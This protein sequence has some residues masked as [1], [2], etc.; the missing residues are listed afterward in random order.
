[1]KQKKELFNKVLNL[2]TFFVLFLI[3]FLIFEVSGNNE[4]KKSILG[5]TTQRIQKSIKIL[6]SLSINKLKSQNNQIHIMFFGDLIYDRSVYLK[7]TG[8][9]QLSGHF[10]YR[11]NQIIL[12]H[13][14]ETTFSKLSKD[15]DFVIFNMEGP[16]GKYYETDKNGRRIKVRKCSAPY[17]SI[18]FCSYSHI[19]PFMKSLGFNAVNLA[20]NH[21]MDGG[22]PGHLETIK[23]L[24]KNQINYFGY[25]Y[26]G[27]NFQRNYILTGQK[28]DI[29]YARHGYDY[30]VY[31]FLEDKY[32]K[33]L[34]DYKKNGYTNFVSVHRGAEYKPIHSD[35][36]ENI[37]KFLIKC[38]ADLIVGH[39]PHVIQDSQIYSGINVIYSLGNFLFDQYFSEPTKIGGYAL[40]D[41]K[42]NQKTSIAKGTIDA[43]AN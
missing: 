8:E 4:L 26:G 35:S 36:Q 30:S 40:I 39:H 21:V 34:K 9:Q 33:T 14:L 5:Q 6:P 42:L 20:N 7:L 43:Y 13:G 3:L 19:L 25:I 32:C 11:H 24:E 17:K 1:M 23:Q 27:R 2:S 16:I 31:Y 37:A 38:G 18:S 29:K 10:N 22:I 15:F 28:D 41:F 12:F